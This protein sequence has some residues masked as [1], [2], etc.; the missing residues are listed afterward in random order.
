MSGERA[1]TPEY[2]GPD[3][4]ILLFAR[5]LTA[6]LTC[7]RF[8]DPLLLS[9]L[10]VKR[11]TFHFFDDVLLLYLPL[12]AAKRIFEGLALLQSDFSQTDYTPLL[13]QNGPLV[14]AS[15]RHLSQ[16]ECGKSHRVSEYQPQ[17]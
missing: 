16:V 5:F 14:M 9:R 7:E 11:V 3:D 8:F 17:P 6:A 12:E 10:Q 1:V 4:S 15:N 2:D 13:V